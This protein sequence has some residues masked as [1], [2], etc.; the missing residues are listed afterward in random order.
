MSSRSEEVQRTRVDR[1]YT[2]AELCEMSLPDYMPC[3]CMTA[4]P[5]P[6]GDPTTPAFCA[7]ADPRSGQGQ[8]QLGV[9]G[10][11]QEGVA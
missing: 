1:V 3:L 2:E 8:R 7:P 4:P 11:Q 9:R 10:K 6:P 5:C